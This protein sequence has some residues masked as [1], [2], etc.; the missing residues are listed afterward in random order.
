VLNSITE[1]D[2]LLIIFGSDIAQ[3]VKKVA[4]GHLKSMVWERG[5]EELGEVFGEL[6]PGNDAC[7]GLHELVQRRGE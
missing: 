7:G 3:G 4:R 5:I 2:L 6:F 1:G